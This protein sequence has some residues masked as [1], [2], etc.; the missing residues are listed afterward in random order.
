[1]STSKLNKPK[2][3]SEF[4]KAITVNPFIAAADR[5]ALLPKGVIGD[6]A[7][8]AFANRPDAPQKRE[9]A[10]S[11]KAMSADSVT[12]RNSEFVSGVT[13]RKRDLRR[14]E[15][16]TIR[17]QFG[18]L[19]RVFAQHIFNLAIDVVNAGETAAASGGF[20]GYD[21]QP[22]FSASHVHGNSGTQK[23]LLT[24]SDVATL[25]VGTATSPT[26]EEAAE[27]LMDVI[28][29]MQS[30]LDHA[31]QGLMEDARS[32]TVLCKPKMSGK[33]RTAIKAN[34][35]AGGENSPVAVANADGFNIMLV[36]SARLTIADAAFVVMVSDR[37]G[38]RATIV[39]EEQPVELN[40]L[41][42]SSDEY[43]KTGK[44]GAIGEWAG[45]HGIGEPLC[46]AKATFS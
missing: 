29:Y 21:G 6:S 18:G 43:K 2:V 8:Y 41:D 16:G 35:L 42:E 17:K 1:M 23:N 13:V 10:Y 20:D 39:Q 30:Y 12:I 11:F 28:A 44:Y 7:D 9:G 34:N 27:A 3:R 5:M 46:A 40:I 22:L 37:E 25:D 36:Q 24:N 38:E 19:G 31:G 26:P 14:D 15:T 45:G 32:F 4:Y 33:F